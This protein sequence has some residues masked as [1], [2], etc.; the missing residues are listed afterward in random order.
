MPANVGRMFY[1]GAVPWHQGGTKVSAPLTL[2]EALDKGDLNW[3]VGEVEVQTAESPSSPAT[4]RKALVRLNRPPGHKQRVLGVVHQGYRP[5]QN[6]AGA[7]LFDTIFGKGKA[8]YHTGGYLGNGEVVW[9]MAKLDKTIEVANGD[10]VQPYALYSNGHGGPY[11]FSI[12]LTTVRVVCQNTLNMA[13]RDQKVA[14]H[15]RRAH[16]GTVREHAEAAEAFWKS[17]MLQCDQ[18]QQAFQRLACRV[19]SDAEFDVL[20]EKLL[21]LPAPLKGKGRVAEARAEKRRQQVLDQRSQVRTLRQKGQGAELV[22]ARG[23]LWGALNAVTEFVDHGEN[24][25]SIST[26]LGRGMQLKQRAYDLVLELE[27][28]PAP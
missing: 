10:V 24:V 4:Q 5:L 13:L 11:A 15:F 2:A 26:L 6:Q 14:S 28:Q 17:A 1:F 3:E 8:V 12:C 25:G 27:R 21:P 9:L 23:T 19:C 7:E 22:T 16:K 20:L 18:A